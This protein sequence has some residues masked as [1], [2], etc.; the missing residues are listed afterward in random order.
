MRVSVTH[1]WPMGHRLQSHGGACRNLHGHTYTARFTF[2][3]PLIASGPSRGMVVDF[4]DVKRLVRDIVDPWDHAMMLEQGDPAAM[5]C[6]PY[7][8]VVCTDEPPTAEHIAALLLAAVRQA[9]SLH[10]EMPYCSEV[11]V[12]ESEATCATAQ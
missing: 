5:A 1:S 10:A 6:R 9:V 2:D 7:G 12:W 11:Q 3:G 8:E 4:K